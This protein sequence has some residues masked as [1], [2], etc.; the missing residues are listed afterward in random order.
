MNK[1]RFFSFDDNYDI[2]RSN[3]NA[4]SDD[5]NDEEDEVVPNLVALEQREDD[6]ERKRGVDDMI[7]EM[8][9]LDIS[10]K[11]RL[12]TDENINPPSRERLRELRRFRFEKPKSFHPERGGKQSLRKRKASRKKL[13]SKKKSFKT[14]RNHKRRSYK[15]K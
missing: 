14:R 12:N 15:K 10:N 6:I 11:K 5:E 8:D 1:K 7:A 3:R 2:K 4:F 13:S 9:A